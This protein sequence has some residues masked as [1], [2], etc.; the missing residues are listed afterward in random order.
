MPGRNCEG[1]WSC[2]GIWTVKVYEDI[3]SSLKAMPEVLLYRS[4]TVNN[5]VAVITRDMAIN[6][7]MKSQVKNRTLHA[8]RLFLLT[9]IFQYIKN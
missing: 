1:I 9:W 2:V 8:Y 5:I 3:W 6:D 7:N 4:N